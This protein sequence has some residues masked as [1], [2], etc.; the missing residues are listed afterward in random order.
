MAP[1]EPISTGFGTIRSKVMEW[2]KGTTSI[3]GTEISNW[4]IVLVVIIVIWIIYKF[5]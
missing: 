2:L 3:A 4:V 5:M 1:A